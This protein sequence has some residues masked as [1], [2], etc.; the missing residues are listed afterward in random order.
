M[1]A[2][3]VIVMNVSEFAEKAAKAL[4]DVGYDAAAL[5]NPYAFLDAMEDAGKIELL[6]TCS[7]YGPNTPN[8]IA[9]ALMARQRRPSLKAIFVGDADLSAFT[10]GVAAFL[11][12]PCTVQ[13]VVETVTRMLTSDGTGALALA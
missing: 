7:D 6:V 11:A 10:D 1:P 5:S 4:R 12:S 2:R 9:L 13:E 8:G 3:V